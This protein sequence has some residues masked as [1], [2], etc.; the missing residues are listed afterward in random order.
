MKVFV[1]M[2]MKM[3]EEFGGINGDDNKARLDQGDDDIEEDHEDLMK[4]TFIS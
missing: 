4:S 1:K 2:K 3:K